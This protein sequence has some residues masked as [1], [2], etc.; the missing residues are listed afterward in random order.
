MFKNFILA[1]F[2]AIA[3]SVVLAAGPSGQWQFIITGAESG[4]VEISEIELRTTDGGASVID[5]FRKYDFE[6]ANPAGNTTWSIAHN[7]GSKAKDTKVTVVAYAVGT[8]AV[9]DYYLATDTSILSQRGSI[10]WVE[11]DYIS[12]TT[13]ATGSEPAT[14]VVGQFYYDT[15]LVGFTQWNGGAWAPY[16]YAADGMF[17]DTVGD[18]FSKW[19]GTSVLTA[20]TVT[21]ITGALPEPTEIEPTSIT[22]EP[23]TGLPATGG[24]ATNNTVTVVFPSAAVGMATIRGPSFD[25]PSINRP[26]VAVPLIEGFEKRSAAAVF[27]GNKG[28][29][30]VTERAPTFR[31]PATIQ[32][33]Y[34]V[35]D[36]SRYPTVVEYAITA[37]TKNSAPKS[38]TVRMYKDGKWEQVDQQAAIRFEDGETRVFEIQ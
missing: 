25:M 26:S 38:W 30:L 20:V 34:W 24:P 15:T 16:E 10:A 19:D 13:G 11:L 37:K 14:P 31:S 28:S 33:T 18:A 32:Y 22:M 7:L 3:T 36:P 8:P 27:D 2:L 9:G 35:G 12:G 23:N 6:E 5:L 4:N 21:E 17:Y 29:W 1:A